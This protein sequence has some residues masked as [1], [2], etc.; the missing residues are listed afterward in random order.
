MR[1]KQYLV[2]ATN[3]RIEPNK[4]Q[5]SSEQA[6]EQQAIGFM[7]M[8]VHNAIRKNQPIPVLDAAG[9]RVILSYDPKLKKWTDS[10]TK[11]TFDTKDVAQLLHRGKDG[12]LYWNY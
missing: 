1:F 6:R 4:T 12:I 2:E 11:D 10:D 3:T 9:K 8:F 7:R 5:V